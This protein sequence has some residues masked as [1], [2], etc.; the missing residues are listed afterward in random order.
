[1]RIE[2][3]PGPTPGDKEVKGTGSGLTVHNGA[4]CK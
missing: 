3:K 2:T 4:K 1:M